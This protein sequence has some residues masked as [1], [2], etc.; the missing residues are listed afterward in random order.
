MDG[1]RI[2]IIAKNKH[3]VLY[4]N[5]YYILLQ[6]ILIF[7]KT[8]SGSGQFHRKPLQLVTPHHLFQ[9]KDQ[10]PSPGIRLKATLSAYTSHILTVNKSEA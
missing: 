7:T 3:K 6:D 9:R 4:I 10:Q 1:A 8:V 2:K 5:S